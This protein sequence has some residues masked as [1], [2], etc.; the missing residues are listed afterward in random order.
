MSCPHLYI[1]L[2]V[3]LILL[4]YKHRLDIIVKKAT[5]LSKKKAYRTNIRIYPICSGRS[6]PCTYKYEI[7][8]IIRMK[9]TSLRFYADSLKSQIATGDLKEVR[10]Y[11]GSILSLRGSIGKSVQ[12]FN[13]CSG[14]HYIDLRAC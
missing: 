7:R 10:S 9:I 2:F 4:D 5:V 14:F 8:I 13:F 11:R 12:M 6:L 3:S 1:K